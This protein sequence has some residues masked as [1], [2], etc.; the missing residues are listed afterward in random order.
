LDITKATASVAECVQALK[1]EPLVLLEAGQPVAVLLPVENADLETVSLSLNP[2]FRAI[3][4]RSGQCQHAEGGVSAEEMR[5]RLGIESTG[6]APRVRGGK[7]E[8]KRP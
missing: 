3:L 8:S 4:E 1:H 2:Q 7:P 5:R 6:E